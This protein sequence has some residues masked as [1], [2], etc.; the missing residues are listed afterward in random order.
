MPKLDPYK[1]LPQQQE[2]KLLVEDIIKDDDVALL[3]IKGTKQINVMIGD[4]HKVIGWRKEEGN[5]NNV[6]GVTI[7]LSGGQEIVVGFAEV[8]GVISEQP[9]G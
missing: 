3:W 8:D 7:K 4:K 1:D 5:P 6:N 2:N 9:V